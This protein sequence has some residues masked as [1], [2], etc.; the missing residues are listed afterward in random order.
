MIRMIKPDWP[1]PVSVRAYTTTRIGGFSKPP[2]N[3][4]N[5][6]T[7]VGDDNEV[8]CSNRQLLARVLSLPSE[9]LWLNQVHGIRVVE[10]KSIP[11]GFSADGMWTTKHQQVCAI[12][13]ADCLPILFCDR[14][15]GTVAAIHAGW[16][17]LASGILEVML[18]KIPVVNK[19]LLIWLGPAI[20]TSA[21]EVGQQVRDTFIKNLPQAQEAFT[22][23]AKA[24][25]LANLY[26]LAKQRLL[27]KGVTNIFGGNFCTYHEEKHFYSYRR[28]KVTGRMATLIWLDKTNNEN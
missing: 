9:P 28:K 4:F 23:K 10:A 26:L 3:E 18:E 2:Y 13:T 20:S 16:K 19:N 17:G 6:A 7:H 8:V 14:N 22:K 21:F 11:N 1:A 15:G 25:W 5:L 24:H 27:R 12:L